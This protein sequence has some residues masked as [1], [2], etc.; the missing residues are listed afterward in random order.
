M[1]TGNGSKN[2]TETMVIRLTS[3]QK[4]GAGKLAKASGVGTA[5]WIRAAIDRALKSNMQLQTRAV[6]GRTA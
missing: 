3:T 2:L 1:E 5:A 6:A 4:R